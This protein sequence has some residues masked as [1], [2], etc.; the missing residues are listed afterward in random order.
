MHNSLHCQLQTLLFWKSPFSLGADLIPILR[1]MIDLITFYKPVPILVEEGKPL[2]ESVLSLLGVFAFFALL[3]SLLGLA[4]YSGSPGEIIPKKIAPMAFALAFV[5]VQV[6]LSSAVVFALS[7][8][9]SKNGDFLKMVSLNFF[10]LSSTCLF[11]LIIT[12][13]F[14][15]FAGLILFPFGLGIYLYFVLG[16]IEKLFRVSSLKSLALLV[17]YIIFSIAL[18]AGIYLAQGLQIPV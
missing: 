14:A 9:V 1:E 8:F 4:V 10:M 5:L 7:R 6:P 2:H 15:E 18:M 3:S 13:P 12:V 17:A 16:I 11:M